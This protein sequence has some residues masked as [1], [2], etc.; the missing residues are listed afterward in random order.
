MDDGAAD[1]AHAHSSLHPD[2]ALLP[3]ARPPGVL[4][5]RHKLDMPTAH[6]RLHLHEP[7][8]HAVLGAVS[9]HHHGV[10]G[11]AAGAPREDAALATNQGS[12]LRGLDQSQLTLYSLKGP[13]AATPVITAP[14]SA[15]SFFRRSS[16]PCSV[17]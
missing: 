8:V 16:P 12:A 3:P 7:V 15:T 17:Q 5:S 11:A 10:V 2:V 6:A 9:H 1:A 13:A 4:A 14:C